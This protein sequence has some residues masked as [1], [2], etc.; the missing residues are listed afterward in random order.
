MVKVKFTARK[1]DA[2]LLRARLLDIQPRA[3]AVDALYRGRG[4]GSCQGS[5]AHAPGRCLSSAPS[6]SGPDRCAQLGLV[7]RADV[8]SPSRPVTAAVD[9]RR[10]GHPTTTAALR[11]SDGAGVISRRGATIA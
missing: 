4:S 8:A 5:E 3:A 6:A 1:K 11:A 7:T 9:G 2:G 10:A